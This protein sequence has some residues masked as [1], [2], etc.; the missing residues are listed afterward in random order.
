MD[1][2]I[3]KNRDFALGFLLSAIWLLIYDWMGKQQQGAKASL[4]T[5]AGVV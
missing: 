2:V 1:Y 4:K 3:I 5:L